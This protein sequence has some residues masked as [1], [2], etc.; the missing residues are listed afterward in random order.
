MSGSPAMKNAVQDVRPFDDPAL[1]DALAQEPL[2]VKIIEPRAVEAGLL[3]ENTPISKSKAFRSARALVGVK[4]AAMTARADGADAKRCPSFQTIRIRD[5]HPVCPTSGPI[6]SATQP[7]SD[8]L[9]KGCSSRQDLY[10]LF[11]PY[12]CGFV[13]CSSGGAVAVLNTV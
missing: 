2:D 8:H 7:S 11:Q 12:D 4:G 10:I 6:P 3:E 9:D 1:R 5:A 13:T